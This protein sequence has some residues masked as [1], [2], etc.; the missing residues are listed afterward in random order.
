VTYHF[1]T[2]EALFLELARLDMMPAIRRLAR[3]VASD[4]SPEEKLRLHIA[5]IIGNYSQKPYLNALLNYLLRDEASETSKAIARDMV[6]PLTTSLETIL[7]DGAAAG[8][9]RVVD[10]AMTYLMIVGA[11]QYAFSSKL[12]VTSVMPHARNQ[13]VTDAYAAA[14]ADMFLRG[15]AP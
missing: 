15:L 14:V 3:L 11:C 13:A 1:G 6:S 5:G 7:I 10:P 12:S 4:A 2:K 8:V 9:F